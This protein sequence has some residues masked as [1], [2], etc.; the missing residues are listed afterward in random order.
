[1]GTARGEPSAVAMQIPLDWDRL[2][3]GDA[4]ENPKCLLLGRIMFVAIAA[5]RLDSNMTTDLTPTS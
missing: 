1:M 5:I 2:P 3:F 4:I